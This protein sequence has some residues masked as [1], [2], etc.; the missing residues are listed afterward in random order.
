MEIDVGRQLRGPFSWRTSGGCTSD[1]FRREP[2]TWSR[3][4]RMEQVTDETLSEEIERIAKDAGASSVAVAV[5]DYRDGRSYSHRGDEWFHAASTIKVPVLIGVYSAVEA[6]LLDLNS[7][8][9]VRNR[10]LS[11]ADGSAYRVEISRDAGGSVHTQIG[12]TMR[13]R[14]LARQMIVTSSNLATNLLIDVVGIDEL[15][16][17][18]DRLGSPGIELSRGVEDDVA[19][20]QG[21]NNR[22]T[23]EGLVGALRL[24]EDAALSPSSSEEML[25]ILH[26]QEFRSGIPAGLPD[27]T[28]VAN[29]TGEISTMA[30]DTGLVYIPGREAYAVAILT[31]WSPSTTARRRE[32][33]ASLSRAVYQ[34]L[35]G[36]EEDA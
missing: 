19:F 22:V 10:F 6:G 18:L 25:D 15:R 33:L 3:P 34:R 36:P 35:R 30:H 8:V 5:H 16:A 2:I 28:R 31:S 23:A 12:K 14:D 20:E 1:G 11:A 26:A 32:A 7:R 24:I 17:A 13:V 9:H 27:G 4:T 29:K 21:I